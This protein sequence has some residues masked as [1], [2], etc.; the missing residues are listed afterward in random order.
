MKLT[1]IELYEDNAGEWRCR[2]RALNGEVIFA[3]TEGYKDKDDAKKN[4]TALADA[5][6]QGFYFTETKEEP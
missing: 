3:S 2:I 1:R 6:I 5:L 4:V